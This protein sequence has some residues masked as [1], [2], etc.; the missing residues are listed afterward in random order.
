MSI[1]DLQVNFS[2]TTA[3]SVGTTAGTYLAPN[4]FDTGPLAAYFTA[5]TASDTTL[6]TT[7]ANAGRDLGGGERIWLVVDMIQT[8]V[9]GT[10][11]NFQLVTQ[12]VST[13]ASPTVVAQTGVIA[14]ATLIAGYRNI[15]ALPRSNVYAQYIGVQTVTTGTYSAGTYYAWLAKDVD[16]VVLGYASGFSIK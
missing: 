1:L 8:S 9:G 6:T 14:T 13:L 15:I 3:T 5:N 11:V 12:S 16:S 7:S 10:N 2:G 4:T